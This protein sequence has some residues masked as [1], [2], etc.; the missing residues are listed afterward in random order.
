MTHLFSRKRFGLALAL[1][2][3]A[4]FGATIAMADD[5]TSSSSP[6]P[7]QQP[8]LPRPGLDHHLK[9]FGPG[10]KVQFSSPNDPFNISNLNNTVSPSLNRLNP[11]LSPLKQVQEDLF[12]P[13]ANAL[14][15]VDSMS[16]VMSVPVEQQEQQQR[17]KTRR[18]REHEEAMRNWAFTD[19]NELYPDPNAEEM[20]GIKQY[21]DT[22]GQEKK[23]VSA[24]EK[25]VNQKNPLQT[26]KSPLQ[27]IQDR[28][29]REFAN[30]T[31][32]YDPT[33]Q[34]YTGQDYYQ[35]TIF[36]P[37]NF[38]GN[39]GAD[40][41]AD[42]ASVSSHFFDAEQS[43]AG[44]SKADLARQKAF[45]KLLSPYTPATTPNQDPNGFASLDHYM[46]TSSAAGNSTFAADQQHTT[47]HIEHSP[48]DPVSPI[49]DPN[50]I[51]HSALLDDPTLHALGLPQPPA[52]LPTPP[53]MPQKTAL[54]IQKM[55]DPFSAT[56]FKSKF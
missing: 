55:I 6:P 9:I 35:R 52:A 49:R 33:T 38:Q 22:T 56:A 51:F 45:E 15:P 31:N 13:L 41:N 19:L 29:V 40:G 34:P 42:P 32:V 4:S 30:G 26:D 28:A 12:R 48:I 39:T 8:A 14:Q 18:T 23:P 10:Q 47:D 43:A 36:T 17:P 27:Q 37:G 24:I 21:D 7:Q 44:P 53:P 3:F 46:A 1:G 16:G 20:F 54:S 11:P 2:A 50:S 25:Y 5:T